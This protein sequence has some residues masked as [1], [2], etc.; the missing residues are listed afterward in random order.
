MPDSITIAIVEDDD[1]IRIQLTGYLEGEGFRVV[2]VDGGAGLDRLLAAGPAPDLIVLDWMLPGEDGLSIC[3]RLRAAS[4]PPIVMLT[5][6]D[7]D[8]DRVLGLEMGADD[9]VSKPFNPRVLLARIRAVLRRSQG[10]GA[11][12]SEDAAEMLGVVD[13]VIDLAARRVTVGEARTEIPLTS[14][15]YDLLHCF[16][17]RPQ[18]VLSRDQLLDWTRGRTADAFDRTIDVQVSRLRHKL[19]ASGSAAAALLKTVRNAGYILAAPV[20]R[21]S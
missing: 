11:P 17:T 1:D 9:Y 2:G 21:A 5:A 20:G 7:E 3:R 18:R 16:V 12:A 13:L 8:I 10:T 6:K 14:A 15:E 19:D 4:G